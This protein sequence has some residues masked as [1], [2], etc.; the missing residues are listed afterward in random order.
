MADKNVFER[1]AEQLEATP[2][3]LQKKYQDI[4]IEV[5]DT[6]F[7]NFRN[8]LAATSGSNSL[9]QTMTTYPALYEGH[10]YKRSLDWDDNIIVNVDKGK[11]YG[12]QRERIRERNKRNYSVYPA[13]YHDLAYIINYG[14]TTENGTRVEGN[15]FIDKARRRLKR[16]EAQRDKRFRKELY[17]IK[18]K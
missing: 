13:T 18:T 8:D 7:Y 2:E 9:N 14:H 4:T 17:K 15:H 1:L 3:A 5:V 16:W 11:A 12:A 6:Y 10:Y